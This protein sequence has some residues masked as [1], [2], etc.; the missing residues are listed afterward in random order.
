MLFFSWIATRV[1]QAVY[2]GLANAAAKIDAGEEVPDAFATLQVRLAIPAAKEPDPAPGEPGVVEP[3][4]RGR[5]VK[6]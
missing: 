5:S 4:R 6:A 1:E 2:Q 3:A